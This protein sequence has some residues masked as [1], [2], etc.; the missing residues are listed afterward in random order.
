M[1]CWINAESKQKRKEAKEKMA[2]IKI[3]DFEYLNKKK[4]Y[5]YIVYFFNTKNHLKY[6]YFIKK[7]KIFRI[8]KT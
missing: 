5:N 7:N 8:L 4:K 2:D 6:K 1:I 3:L